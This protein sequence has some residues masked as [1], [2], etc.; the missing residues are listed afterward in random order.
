[1][2]IRY[3]SSPSEVKHMD[4][5]DLRERFLVTDIFKPGEINLTYTHHDRIVVGGAV[6]GTGTRGR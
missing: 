2:E 3:P 4:T 6:P 1:M 5:A